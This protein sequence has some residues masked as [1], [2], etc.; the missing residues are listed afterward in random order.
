VSV[1]DGA[2][3]INSPLQSID[4]IMVYDNLG[5]MMFQKD[6]ISNSTFVIPRLISSHQMLVVSILLSDGTKVSRK[7]IY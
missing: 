1:K 5:R 4:K 2:I 6:T 7:I 3:K